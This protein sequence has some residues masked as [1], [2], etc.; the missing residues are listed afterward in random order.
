MNS[1]L[2][3]YGKVTVRIKN[4]PPIRKHNSGTTQ[5]FKVL[6]EALADPANASPNNHP[7]YI[8][9]SNTKEPSNVTYESDKKLTV[10]ELYINARDVTDNGVKFTALL[11][12]NNISSQTE[13]NS[14]DNLLLLDGSRTNVLAYAAV[15][16]DQAKIFDT[17]KNDSNGQ[18]VIEWEM[19][20]SNNTQ[21]G[22]EA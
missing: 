13:F 17:V 8:C 14:S 10:S 1:N 3:Y 22:S 18:C 9:I 16:N 15:S 21:G 6:Y 11:N 2:I 20:F 19:S 12:H 5:L 4:K 7:G